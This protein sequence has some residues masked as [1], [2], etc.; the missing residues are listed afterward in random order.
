MNVSVSVY[1]PPMKC[2]KVNGSLYRTDVEHMMAALVGDDGTRVTI[3]DVVIPATYI[4]RRGLLKW[5]V[6]ACVGEGD[7][8]GWELRTELPPE[9]VVWYAS[10]PFAMWAKAVQAQT[11]LLGPDGSVWKGLVTFPDARSTIWPMVVEAVTAAGS[12]ERQ[13]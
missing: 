7:K 13:S 10:D 6:D 4:R 3:P 12:L 8:D 2:T 5:L 11:T 9:P 1:C